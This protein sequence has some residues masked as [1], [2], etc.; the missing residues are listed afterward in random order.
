MP[1]SLFF[2]C[3]KNVSILA[4][5]IL[6]SNVDAVTYLNLHTYFGIE[7]IHN[8]ALFRVYLNDRRELCMLGR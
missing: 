6:Y 3:L 1:L 5:K 4:F 7:E 8:S 2:K